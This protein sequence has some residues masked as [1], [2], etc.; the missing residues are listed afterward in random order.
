MLSASQ[1]IL[2]SLTIRVKGDYIQG[3]NSCN[4]HVIGPRNEPKYGLVNDGKLNFD[5]YNSIRFLQ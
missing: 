4:C 3:E 2:V 5:K 1:C